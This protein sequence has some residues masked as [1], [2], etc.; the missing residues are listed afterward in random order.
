MWRFSSNW[1]RRR[2]CWTSPSGCRRQGDNISHIDTVTSY[3]DT[4]IS[5]IDTV[6]LWS[7]SIYQYC[8]LPCRY[9]HLNVIFHI[10]TAILSSCGLWQEVAGGVQAVAG[11]VQELVGRAAFIS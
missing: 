8:Q 4:V 3:I 2:L 1:C 9:S 5:H 7:A 11:G 6:I 10:D